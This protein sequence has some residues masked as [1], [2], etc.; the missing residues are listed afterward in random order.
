MVALPILWVLFG[1][2]AVIVASQKG[3]SGCAW[4]AMGFLL[5]P[6]GLLFILLLPSLASP[7]KESQATPVIKPALDDI[8]LDQETKKCP[9]CAEIIKL[10]A[11][12]CRY[13]GETFSKEDV[14]KAKE[15]WRIKAEDYNDPKF[16]PMCRKKDVVLN[17]F[18]PDGS[19]GSWCPNC[20]K[21]IK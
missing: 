2:A 4:F 3:R 18:L 16:C 14:E 10:E 15:N 20:K 8:S 7:S 11:L 13:C 12:K 6:F 9:Q 17:A 1:I 21:P 5:G 19:Y